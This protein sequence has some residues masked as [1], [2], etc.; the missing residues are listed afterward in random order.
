M[1]WVILSGTIMGASLAVL[2]SFSVHTHAVM[3]PV[4]A[5]IARYLT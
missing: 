4:A 2:S 3:S 1:R 5:L